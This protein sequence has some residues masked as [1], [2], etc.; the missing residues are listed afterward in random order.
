[1]VGEENI[2]KILKGY[3]E[4]RSYC[5]NTLLR[6]YDPMYEVGTPIENWMSKQ[7]AMK[8]AALRIGDGDSRY[9]LTL[10]LGLSKRAINKLLK[11]TISV[12]AIVNNNKKTN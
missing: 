8:E 3:Q 1:M 2:P 10:A 7:P 9:N 5:D 11:G 4:S 12:D 6:P